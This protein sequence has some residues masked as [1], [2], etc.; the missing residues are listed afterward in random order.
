MAGCGASC[1]HKQIVMAYREEYQR[2]DDELWERSGGY[3]TEYEDNKRQLRE[4]GT[5]LPQFKDWLKGMKREPVDE[6]EPAGTRPLGT[7]PNPWYAERDGQSFL[8]F[9]NNR[10]ANEGMLLSTAL[11]SEGG[12]KALRALDLKEFYVPF[13]Q[14]VARAITWL[15]DRGLPHDAAAVTKLLRDYDKLPMD[16]DPAVPNRSLDAKLQVHQSAPLDL[17]TPLAAVDPEQ[18]GL[19]AWETYSPP[20]VVAPVFAQ[21]VRSEYRSREMEAI[22]TRGAALARGAIEYSED[23]LV[24][25]DLVGQVRM[26]MANELRE[27]PPAL[28]GNLQPVKRGDTLDAQVLPGQRQLNGQELSPEILTQVPDLTVIDQDLRLPPAPILSAAGREALT[29]G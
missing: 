19:G 13:H 25:S 6:P 21:A 4:A 24:D 5:P 27:F 1:G 16:M 7:N 26:K 14:D 28:D 17:D 29:R 23:G 2:Q 3:R 10:D 20:A 22:C 8:R 15:D 9:A 11:S 18:W 12:V